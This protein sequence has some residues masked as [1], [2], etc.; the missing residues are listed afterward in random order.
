MAEPNLPYK[1]ILLKISG[2]VLMGPLGYGIDPETVMRIAWDVKEVHDRKMQICLVIG[3]GN[4][5]RGAMG[6]GHGIDRPTADS[7]GMLATVMNSLAIQSALESIGVA[8]RVM[9]GLTISGVCEPYIRRKALRHLEKSRVVIFA[10]GTGNP[11]FTTDTAGALRA[12]EMNCDLLLKG[13]K[14]DGIY[15]S[16]PLKNKNAKH[17]PRLSYDKALQGNLQVMDMTAIVLARDNKLPLMV[18]SIQKP[19]N[20]AK[21]LRG[22]GMFSYIHPGE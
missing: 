20:V 6:G 10:A 11:Y 17:Y 18:F 15:S 3:G 9:S 13:T 7:M 4:I 16:D 21:V 2:E 5:F 8:V 12:C 14:V 19:G 22:E 1:R